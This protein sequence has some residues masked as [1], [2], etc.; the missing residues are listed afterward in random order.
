MSEILDNVWNDAE[1]LRMEAA[2]IR[3]GVSL[4]LGLIGEIAAG[5]PGLGIMAGLGF[6]AVDKFWGMQNDS[7]S[8]KIAKFVNPNYLVS[9]YD[10][11]KKHALK[12]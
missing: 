7:V 5:L 4:N 9:I 12:N 8:E 3:F 1:R 10:F 11:K 6:T 2:G